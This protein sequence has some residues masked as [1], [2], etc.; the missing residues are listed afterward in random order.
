MPS[1]KSTKKPLSASAINALKPG[2]LLTDTGENAGLRVSCAKSGI[3]TFFYR[4]RSPHQNLVK[5]ITIGS[6]VSAVLDEDL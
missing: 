5:R 6:Y 2:G 1:D 4:Y 3:K